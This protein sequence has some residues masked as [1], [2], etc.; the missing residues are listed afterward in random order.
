MWVGFGRRTLS[1]LR[2]VNQSPFLVFLAVG[3]STF[4]RRH[5]VVL[6]VF[7][8]VYLLRNNNSE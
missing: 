6:A 5:Y 3:R 4:A 1:S 2:I 8:N 7:T